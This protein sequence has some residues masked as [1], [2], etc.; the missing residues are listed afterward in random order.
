MFGF[1]QGSSAPG[2]TKR[3]Y[4]SRLDLLAEKATNM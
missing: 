1:Q 2:K 3:L 4:V